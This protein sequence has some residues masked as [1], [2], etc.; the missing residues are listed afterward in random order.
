M[1]TTCHEHSR[2]LSDIA[3][4]KYDSKAQW[5]EINSLRA[6]L[7]SI[8]L[9]LNVAIG[10]IGIACILLALDLIVRVSGV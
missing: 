7:D 5:V 10:G 4:L 9:R 6:K 8:M 3:N 2:C 1:S